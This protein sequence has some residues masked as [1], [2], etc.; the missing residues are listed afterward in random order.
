MVYVPASYPP[1]VSASKARVCSGTLEVAPP[2]ST[3]T[4]PHEEA[5]SEVTIIPAECPTP[6]AHLGHP[7]QAD[8]AHRTLLFLRELNLLIIRRI[9]VVQFLSLHLTSDPC[10][11]HPP[12]CNSIKSEPLSVPAVLF[13][14]GHGHQ[15]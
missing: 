11:E 10:P 14:P 13:N 9:L 12:S 2:Y 5:P 6:P 7:P 15:L 4:E 8:R 3:S 1:V